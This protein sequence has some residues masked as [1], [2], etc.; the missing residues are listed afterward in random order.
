MTATPTPNFGLPQYDESDM[1][2]LDVLLNG[3]TS[4]LDTSLKAQLD[5]L[6]SSFDPLKADT[7]WK[8]ITSGFEPGV[9][10]GSTPG[11]LQYRVKGGI[12]YWRGGV[13]GAFPPGYT[14]AV[15]NLPT[16]ARPAD[17]GG[18]PIRVG[19]S[20]SSAN[21]AFVEIYSAGNLVVAHNSG[22]NRAWV[23][24]TTSYPQG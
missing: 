15:T 22:S 6:H 5:I 18:Q 4:Q 23:A 9:G 17:N 10:T 19:A 8:N 11:Q 12:V 7:G 20:S 2:A 14:T 16:A 21:P 3:V 1:G 24:F 13:T